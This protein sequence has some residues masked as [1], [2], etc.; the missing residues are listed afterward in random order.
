MTQDEIYALPV[1]VDDVMRAGHCPSGLR[2]WLHSMDISMPRFFAGE[3][4]V[5]EIL[6]TDDANG[7]KVVEHKL[8]LMGLD[9]G[10]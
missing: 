9:N 10:R 3:V 7:T 1:T 8:K 4:T 2:R 5:G 6:A